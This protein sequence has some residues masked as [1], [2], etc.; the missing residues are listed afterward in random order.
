[1]HQAVT[2]LLPKSQ[3]YFPL[4]SITRCFQ[5]RLDFHHHLVRFILLIYRRELVRH[6]Q[7]RFL[8]HG[9][10]HPSSPTFS[11]SSSLDLSGIARETQWFV[12]IREWLARL[13]RHSRQ[14]YALR[15]RKEL[16]NQPLLR[17]GIHNHQVRRVVVV[18][19]WCCTG[20]HQVFRAR[21][22]LISL[23]SFHS[24]EP[25]ASFQFSAQSAM[26]P[27]TLPRSGRS[28]IHVLS[29]DVPVILWSSSYY[30][31]SRQLLDSP[32]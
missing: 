24:Q 13:L 30:R 20:A 2:W 19:V 25:L 11:S 29:R 10:H 28:P 3:Q 7:T 23:A 1:M 15:H 5:Q 14:S 4:G 6:C 16:V 9:F 27:E 12:R 26:T 8:F 21:F 22:L 18:A 17:S 31:I 32:P